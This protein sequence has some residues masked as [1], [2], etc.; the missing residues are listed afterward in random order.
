MASSPT[1]AVKVG[2]IKRAKA[3][4]FKQVWLPSVAERLMVPGVANAS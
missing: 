4:G 3:L 2:T 1:D